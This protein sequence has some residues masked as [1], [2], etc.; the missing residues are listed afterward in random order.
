MGDQRHAKAMTDAPRVRECEKER[1]RSGKRSV[2]LILPHLNTQFYQHEKG[3]ASTSVQAPNLEF[4]HLVN[5]RY[6]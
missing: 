1:E 2:V 4:R 5:L 3:N 6:L